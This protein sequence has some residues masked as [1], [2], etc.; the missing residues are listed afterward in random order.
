MSSTLRASA[1]ALP[2][3]IGA[4]AM[5]DADAV[6]LAA[7]LEAGQ[8][9]SYVYHN[10]L[11]QQQFAKEMLVSEFFVDYEL[12]FEMT[13]VQATE[14]YVD[15]EL[16]FSRI[17]IDSTW[18]VFDSETPEADDATNLTAQA[19]RPVIGET[20]NVR[21]RS[22]M[23]ILGITGPPTTGVPTDLYKLYARILDDGPLSE[24]LQPIF[25]LK[26]PAEAL[27]GEEWTRTVERRTSTGGMRVNIDLT[28]D[29]VGE[30]GVAR[31]RVGGEHVLVEESAT[32][33]SP[34]FEEQRLEGAAAW[35]TS[36]SRLVEYDLMKDFVLI[37]GN[38]QFAFKFSVTEQE[39]LESRAD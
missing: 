13:V 31:V 29:D 23:E 22:N 12:E 26:S 7:D 1:L 36:E 38:E 14:V 39:R 33:V 6:R 32:P 19:F 25:R 21:L 27:P 16:V 10:T 24:S 35:D 34:R 28:L 9:L 4:P 18:G 20:F 3:V 2:M 8:T 17:E 5:A 37:A 15:L 30:D 11:N